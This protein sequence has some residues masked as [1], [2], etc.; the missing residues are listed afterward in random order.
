APETRRA[1][2]TSRDT[3]RSTASR[4]R[5]AAPRPAT[6]G[7]GGAAGRAVAVS[8]RR[9]SCSAPGVTATRSQERQAPGQGPDAAAAAPAWRRLAR[10]GTACASRRRP[11]ARRRTGESGP[12]RPFVRVRASERSVVGGQYPAT[13]KGDSPRCLLIKYAGQWGW[14]TAN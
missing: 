14:L 10:A 2:G 7:T 3:R 8:P 1:R 9:R 5:G 11:S 4:G 12:V 6:E 13:R